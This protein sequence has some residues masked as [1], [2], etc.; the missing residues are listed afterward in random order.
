VDHHP[1]Q[2]AQ[3]EFK[4]LTDADACMR[5]LHRAT[6]SLYT[7]LSL[8]GVLRRIVTAAKMLTQ[9]RFAAVGISNDDGKLETFIHLG[10]DD[11][12]ADRIAHPPEGLGLLGEMIRTQKSIRIP[13][14]TDH[15][16]SYGFP[17]GHPKMRSFLGV[18]ITAFGRPI[19]QIYLTDKQGAPEFSEQDEQLIELL[20]AQSG[21]AI[22]NARLYQEVTEGRAE[23]S[24]RNEELELINAIANAVSSTIELEPLLEAMLLRVSS[25]FGAGAGE[26]FLRE[27]GRKKFRQ[28]M[29]VG[30]AKQVFATNRIYHLGEG[31]VG[32]VAE[33]GKPMWSND[34]A[35]ESRL[36]RP[37]V[38]EAG[39]NTLVSVPLIGKGRV[40]GVLNLAFRGP[41]EISDREV[42]L[43]SA[44][45]A[46]VGIA[47]EHARLSRQARRV[48]VLEE[49]ERI[50]MD[51]H[52]GIIQ[53]IYATGL[54]LDSLRL[55]LAES[56]KKAETV[57]DQIID[58]LNA[59]IRDI[60]SYIL[61]LQP[62]RVKSINFKD[63]IHELAREFRAN[64]MLDLEL[65][66]EDKAVDLLDRKTTSELFLIAQEALAN[67]AKHAEATRVW[68]TVRN[69]GEELL[70]QV[71][72]NGKG[73]NP[74][75]HGRMMGHGLSNI[76]QRA[77]SIGG[78]WH[79]TSSPDEGTT[80]TVRLAIDKAPRPAE[81]LIA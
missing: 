15:P 66:L 63:A 70:L 62:T 10:M 73:F 20:A 34:L 14:I 51:L 36:M 78:N 53:S 9:A 33:S 35:G 50:A 74:E 65:K 37:A 29:H 39:F 8:E 72:D 12:E 67:V 81:D 7:D 55:L 17:D 31:F 69:A 18:P 57:L 23:L 58:G 1:Q 42:G 47:I 25:L 71:I 60:R 64:T 79:I 22:A 68:L 26:I 2:G 56:P 24:Q 5:A 13:E 43:L 38:V 6:L 76:E 54:T 21:A 16:S 44:M 3:P 59:V 4:N 52:D 41:R 61:D 27:E 45:G 40:V 48:A 46:G 11:A 80:V 19:G 49:R 32:L 75:D 28:A 30:E 77:N